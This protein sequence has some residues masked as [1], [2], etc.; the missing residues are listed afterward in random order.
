MV[1]A[2]RRAGQL[3]QPGQQDRGLRGGK[4]SEKEVRECDSA[5]G[6][7]D[8]TGH[9]VSQFT[10][11]NN[12]H[13]NNIMLTLTSSTRRASWALWGP[14][15]AVELCTCEQIPPKESRCEA[16]TPAQAGSAR[17]V[18]RGSECYPAMAVQ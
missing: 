9:A 10:T 15:A 1:P 11:A 7:G 14:P 13:T 12:I 18:C 4:N 16:C 6:M 17:S 3:V 8:G 2:V 5:Q